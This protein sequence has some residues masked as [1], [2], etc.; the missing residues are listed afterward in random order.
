MRVILVPVAGRPE[1]AVALDCAFRLAAEHGG[2]VVACHVR[3]HRTMPAP[4][5]A[6]PLL[7]ADEA[8]LMTP[9][10]AESARKAAHKLFDERAAAHEF[11]TRK[12]PSSRRNG[13]AIWEEFVG[14]PGRALAIVGPISDML[15]LTRP[16]NRHSHKS[17]DF[18][19]AAV[20]HSGRP[21][22]VLPP[23]KRSVP[24]KR[25]AIC[26]DQSIET[27]LAV[28]GAMPMLQKAEAVTIVSRGDEDG[29][30]PKSKHLARYLTHWGIKAEIDHSE[31]SASAKEIE[32]A[33][34]KIDADLLI[35][36]AYTHGKLRERLFGGL[37]EHMLFKSKLSVLM[38][39]VY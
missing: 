28:H 9:R 33:C 37:T 19:L 23:K 3:P 8:A 15:I 31:R 30:G 17:R 36:G 38:L 34:D 29:V 32:K 7:H 12:R 5:P 20:L 18:L 1:S 2:D 27:A 11:P 22:L 14:S 24:G 39:E 16:T 35:M 6:G 10:Q 21:V 4:D 26:W 25:I 13:L